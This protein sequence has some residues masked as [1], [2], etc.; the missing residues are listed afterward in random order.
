MGRPTKDVD[1][2]YLEELIAQG[3][4]KKEIS[5]HL[6]MTTPTLSRRIVE[7]KEKEGEILQYRALQSLELTEIEARVLEAITPS[8]IHA[9]SLRDLVTAYKILKDKELVSDGKPSEIKGLVGYLMQLEKEDNSAPSTNPSHSHKQEDVIEAEFSERNVSQEKLTTMLEE[10]NHR[11]DIEDS[12]E[13]TDS[14]TED[15]EEFFDNDF[16]FPENWETSFS[17]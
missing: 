5:E 2:E 3:Y 14:E 4:S 15:D 1:Q 6:G 11:E 8:K 9:A 13:S 17:D 16:K 10:V 7:L 12:L